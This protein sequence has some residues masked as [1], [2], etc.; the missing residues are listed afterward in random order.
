MP[1]LEVWG[2]KGWALLEW[3]FLFEW[4]VFLGCDIPLEW[5]GLSLSPGIV[6][7]SSSEL[8][9]GHERLRSLI[10]HE[11]RHRRRR[12]HISCNRSRSRMKVGDGAPCLHPHVK[13]VPNL[14]GSL[15]N[16]TLQGR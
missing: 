8:R 16:K 7:D 1:G 9:A 4:D 12:N 14:P 3:D 11:R 6:K 5:A 15:V 2:D 10:W 13:A